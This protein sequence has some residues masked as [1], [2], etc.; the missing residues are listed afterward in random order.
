MVHKMQ[1]QQSTGPAQMGMM[2]GWCGGNIN[3]YGGE[4]LKGG[5]GD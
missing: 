5:M 4:E 3:V 1:T 2:R